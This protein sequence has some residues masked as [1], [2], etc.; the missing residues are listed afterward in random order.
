[1]MMTGGNGTFRVLGFNGR[2]YL[3]VG[4]LPDGWAVK[5]ITVDGDDVTNQPIDLSTGRNR[6]VRIVLTDRVT[7]VTGSV[8]GATGAGD[9]ERGDSTV[10][11]FS[12]DESKWTYPSRYLRT[13]RSDDKGGFRIRGL[14]AN[15]RYLAVAVDYLEDGE[16]SDPEFLERM[17]DRA[18]AFSLADAERKAIDL[19]LIQ[20]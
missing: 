17:K 11:V 1:M 18:T 14:P 16:G 5:S 2:A 8:D 3:Q 12:Q 15:E 4:G 13:T 10:V 7:E 20:R 6:N 19:R 9:Q